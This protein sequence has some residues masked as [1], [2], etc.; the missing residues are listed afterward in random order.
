MNQTYFP[1]NIFPKHIFQEKESWRKA[2]IKMSKKQ[3]LLQVSYKYNRVGNT[4]RKQITYR[5]DMPTFPNDKAGYI[6][7][8]TAYQ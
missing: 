7:K 2:L 3:I 8:A 5:Q 1:R 4:D 6:E